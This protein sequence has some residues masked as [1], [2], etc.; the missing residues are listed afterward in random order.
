M[1]AEAAGGRGPMA[2][3]R[4]LRGPTTDKLVVGVDSFVADAMSTHIALGDL[5]SAYDG[6]ELGP[7]IPD[8]A[9]FGI[10]CDQ[11]SVRNDD[12]RRAALKY[13]DGRIS[14]CR[15]ATVEALRVA[16]ASDAE[17]QG[18]MRL[19]YR[20][21]AAQRTVLEAKAQRIGVPVLTYLFGIFREWCANRSREQILVA[22]TVTDRPH[23]WEDIDSVVGPFTE[24]MLHPIE[25][26][27]RATAAWELQEELDRDLTYRSMTGTEILRERSI[28]PPQVVYSSVTQRARGRGYPVS[29]SLSVTSGSRFMLTRPGRRAVRCSWTGTSIRKHWEMKARESCSTSTAN[30]LHS[31]S[32]TALLCL[33]DRRGPRSVM[34]LMRLLPGCR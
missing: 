31:A 27:A 5:W 20:L 22:L 33:K 4:I 15:P 11:E 14:G 34:A 2:T 10:R 29:R 7:D 16:R 8:G 24:M 23:E 17:S 21:T 28:D 19:S 30:S 3:L 12:A 1:L 32:L 18:W 9:F 13:W 6:A 25:I 26:G